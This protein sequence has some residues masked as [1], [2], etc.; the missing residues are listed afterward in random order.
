LRN[1]I[2]ELAWA[3]VFSITAA[4]ALA[5]LVADDK[6]A[7]IDIVDKVGPTITSMLAIA[8]AI[9]AGR[10][11]WEGVQAQIRAAEEATRRASVKQEIAILDAVTFDVTRASAVLDHWTGESI[12]NIGEIAAKFKIEVFAIDHSAGLAVYMFEENLREF[13]Q[14]ADDPSKRFATIVA[15]RKLRARAAVISIGLNTLNLKIEKGEKRQAPY[16]TDRDYFEILKRYAVQ[17][18]DLAYANALR[19]GLGN[20]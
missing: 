18:A 15:L 17:E 2:G 13:V 5:M 19:K 11:A 3:V 7:P 6:N 8:A 12:G 16:I 1:E 9:W 14:N 4:A 10:K 20:A